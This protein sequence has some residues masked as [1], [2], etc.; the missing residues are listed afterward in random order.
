[1][2]ITQVPAPPAAKRPP[3]GARVPDSLS[4]MRQF[5]QHEDGEGAGTR[6][7]AHSGSAGVVRG[8][9]CGA[10]GTPGRLSAGPPGRR[11]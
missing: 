4:S 7:T 1:V 5:Q 9:D 2:A 11:E 8:R 10:A 6:T 3:L